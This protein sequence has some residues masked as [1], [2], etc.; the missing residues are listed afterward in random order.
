MI[1]K[2]TYK[3]IEWLDLESPSQEEVREVIE[4]Y[5]LNIAAAEELLLP[6]LKPKAELYKNF[7]YLVLHFPAFKHTHGKRTNQEIDFII[8]K[9]F[10]ITTRYDTID[11][12]H[13]FSKVFEV[14]SI[15]EREDFG[16]HAG[17]LF[18]YIIRKLYRS[19]AHELDFIHDS[20]E[21]IQDNIFK[22]REKAMVYDL[23]T[24][25]RNLTSFIQ[26]T[27]THREVLK[28]FESA[29]RKFFGDEFGYYASSITDEFFKIYNTVENDRLLLHEVRET[30][31]S[32]LTTKQNEV[33]KVLTIISLIIF[34]LT[35]FAALFSMTTTYKP[36][37]GMRFDFWIILGIMG[38]FTVVMLTMFRL[39]KWL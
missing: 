39:K 24:I 16:E 13:K 10:L 18:Y 27:G 37:V 14:N 31:N 8:G 34:P 30:N 19:L 7:I 26:A 33:I 6:S 11:P 25:S 17:F 28:S 1:N 5:D 4:Q 3:D 23:S 2:Y 38:L 21:E 36:I 9:N 15:L 32:L 22:G 20:L 35:L 12:I 29:S